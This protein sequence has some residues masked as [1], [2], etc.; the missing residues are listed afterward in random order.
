MPLTTNDRACNYFACTTNTCPL[1][2][3]VL[4]THIIFA[5]NIYARL[6]L[7]TSVLYCYRLKIPSST[8]TLHSIG[9]VYVSLYIKSAFVDFIG[10]HCHC[11]F[12]KE[13]PL[14]VCLTVSTRRSSNN[15]ILHKKWY[16]TWQNCKHWGLSEI[17]REYKLQFLPVT[18]WSLSVIV[19]QTLTSFFSKSLWKH[20]GTFGN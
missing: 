14:W 5:L 13:V 9:C 11:R 2:T 16:F 3:T 15:I 17:Q 19:H 20:I 4:L 12:V 7:L 1:S 6:F 8:N 18:V 10:T